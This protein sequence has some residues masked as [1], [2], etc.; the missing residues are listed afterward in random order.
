[1]L[2][3]SAPVVLGKYLLSEIVS[4]FLVGYPKAHVSLEVTDRVA[5]MV[6]EG[7]DLCVRFGPKPS[8]S[9]LVSRVIAR[10][11]GGLYASATYLKEHGV[12]RTP[13]DLQGHCT[14]SLGPHDH[15]RY[16]NLHRN[17][18]SAKL[19]LAPR[20]HTN[21]I[22][23]LLNAAMNG[24]GICMA[25]HFVCHQE[26]LPETLLQVLPEW[27]LDPIEVRALY[28]SRL[29]VTPLLRA[30]LDILA[31]RAPKSLN[32]RPHHGSEE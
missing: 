24:C 30:F 16:W 31:E 1:M 6:P 9:T 27:E 13:E 19:L 26:K 29:S 2:R 12:P 22:P 17:S 20:M 18:E 32:I 23:T 8:V 28:P 14:L 21:D 7:I 25:P 5:D 3:I 15:K 11:S 10:P 4:R